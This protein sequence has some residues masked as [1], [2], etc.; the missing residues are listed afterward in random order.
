MNERAVHLLIEVEV[1]R[2]EGAVG[3]AKAGLL[4]PARDEPVLAPDEFVA[5]KRRDEIDGRLFLGLGL[6]EAHFEHTGHARETELAQGVI[7][8]DEVHVGSPVWRSMRSR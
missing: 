6:A 7:E 1:K 8:F 4:Q 5:D 2:I 3:V